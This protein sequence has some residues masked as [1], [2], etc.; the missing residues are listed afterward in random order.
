[1]CKRFSGSPEIN[2]VVSNTSSRLQ[3]S[4][5]AIQRMK[6]RNISKKDVMRVFRNGLADDA[7]NDCIVRYIP[8]NPFFK[9]MSKKIEQLR[10]CQIIIS[11]DEVLIT[12]MW[13]EDRR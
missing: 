5:H 11:R 10:G 4:H 9:T 13:K 6:S 7:R 8:E 1:M 12:V 3:F 2:S